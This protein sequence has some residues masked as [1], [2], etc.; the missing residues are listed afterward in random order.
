MKRISKYKGKKLPRYSDGG[1]NQ[2]DPKNP[3]STDIVTPSQEPMDVYMTNL[4][5]LKSEQERVNRVRNNIVPTA[6]TIDNNLNPQT[7]L[8]GAPK[9]GNFCNAYTGECYNRAGLTTAQDF[10]LNGRTVKAGSPMPMIPGNLQQESVLNQE[11]FVQ[12]PLSEVQP[13]DN[14]KKQYYSKGLPW[15]G[16]VN[17]N[18]QPHWISGHSM[19]YKGPGANNTQEVYNSP[20]DRNTFEKRTFKSKDWVGNINNPKEQ[21]SRLIAYRYVGNIPE[22]EKQTLEARKTSLDNSKPLQ[23]I[24]INYNNKPQ[25]LQLKTP[26]FKALFAEQRQNI[27]NS[28]MSA[29]KKAEMLLSIDQRE[30]KQLGMYQSNEQPTTINQTIQSNQYKY[31]GYNT[32]SINN[33]IISKKNKPCCD[34]KGNLKKKRGLPYTQFAIGGEVDTDPNGNEITSEADYNKRLLLPNKSKEEIAAQ[35]AWASK[36]NLTNKVST[37]SWSPSGPYGPV[38]DV[39]SATPTYRGIDVSERAIEQSKLR[40]EEKDR[41]ARKDKITYDQ[42]VGEHGKILG[43]LSYAAKKGDD[44]ANSTEPGGGYETAGKALEFAAMS[45]MPLFEGVGLLKKPI[46]TAGKWAYNSAARSVA[47]SPSVVSSID[48]V[49]KE[50]LERRAFLQNL[51]DRKLIHPDADIAHF[52]QSDDLVSNLTKDVV[53]QKN[54]Y[55]RGVK[56]NLPTDPK[57]LKAMEQAGVDLTNKESIGKYYAT[58]IKHGELDY[59]SGF[60]T[61]NRNHSALYTDSGYSGYG[62]MTF[63]MKKATDF[64]KGNYKDWIDDLYKYEDYNPNVFKNIDDVPEWTRTFKNSSDK[65]APS[66]FVGKKGQKIFDNAKLV[67]V[68]DAGKGFGRTKSYELPGSLN[69]DFSKYLTQEEAV[70]ARAERLISQKNK[71]GWNEQLTPELEQRLSN[72][73]KNHNPASDYAG[74]SLGANTMGRTATEVSKNAISEGIPLNNANK[75]RIAA[76]ET[77]HYYSNSPAEGEEWLKS[78]NLNSLEN[79][80]TR[81]YLRGKGR[82]AN[83][84]NEIRERAA[85]LKDYIAQKNNIPLNQDFKI[86][87]AQLDDAIENYVKDTGLDNT[88]SKMLGALKDKKGLLKTMNKYALGTVPAVVGVTDALQQKKYGGMM[89][90]MAKKTWAMG[91]MNMEQEIDPKPATSSTKTFNNIVPLVDAKTGKPNWDN[92]Y[93]TLNKMGTNIESTNPE[94]KQTPAQNA[95]NHYIGQGIVPQIKTYQGPLNIGLANKYGKAYNPTTGP[96]TNQFLDSTEGAA[97]LGSTEAYQDFLNNT[98]AYNDYRGKTQITGTNTTGTSDPNAEM[99]GA[100]YYNMFTPGYTAPLPQQA[101]GGQFAMGGM[102]MKQ[103]IIHAPEMGG[104]FKK[105]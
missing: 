40:K 7:L 41:Q 94:A 15:Q 10:L 30:K 53:N 98:K 16:P 61:L 24:N 4:G 105:K 55:Y 37:Y 89:N 17:S 84:A 102:T 65:I 70:A 101:L 79:Y 27:N 63:E 59:G 31:G 44:W 60:S 9:K 72:A 8:R 100:R 45:A 56:S 38:K 69:V 48:N 36:K 46:T 39:T 34:E 90:Y 75:A 51:K 78:F 32:S 81:T 23:S 28:K 91:G 74:K 92:Y 103:G 47:S 88:M 87:Q 93:S 42:S 26:N 6:Q 50:V 62:D 99:Y 43:T 25:E 66:N 35:N 14:I 11:G 5:V 19:I 21:D 22:L 85:Q 18:A 76:H 71:P 49:G 96:T 29:K 20:G 77:G 1:T 12:V 52:A 2:V 54:T 57:A 82:S 68:D 64:N 33:N 67:K 80:K 95:I 86:T 3:G 13:G 97:A 104:Y 83:Y 58:H 73:V